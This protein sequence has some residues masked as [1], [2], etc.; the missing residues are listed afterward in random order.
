MIYYI[1]SIWVWNILKKKVDQ[2]YHIRNLLLTLEG[3]FYANSAGMSKRV[4]F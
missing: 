2:G 3:R 4:F 1:Y